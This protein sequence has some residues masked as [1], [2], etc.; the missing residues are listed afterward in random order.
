MALDSRNVVYF[1]EFGTNKLAKIDRNSMAIT[2]YP[3]PDAGARPRRLAIGPDDTI[4]YTD[5][6]RGMLGHL[7]PV[8]GEV[9]EFRFADPASPTLVLDP[10]DPGLQY[11]LMPLRV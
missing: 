11:V 8:T 6:A 2:E 10:E 5:F 7:D 3:R 4:W 1:V 9:A